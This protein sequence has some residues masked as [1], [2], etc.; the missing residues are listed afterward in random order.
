MPPGASI[1]YVGE[2]VAF[3]N[4]LGLAASVAAATED[5]DGLLILEFIQA[6]RYPV[7]R[8][9]HGSGYTARCKFTRRT[10]IDQ[11]GAVANSLGQSLIIRLRE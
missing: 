8:N 3:E 5:D 9:I 7:Q 2:T 6:R 11:K 10:H 4:A 1:E